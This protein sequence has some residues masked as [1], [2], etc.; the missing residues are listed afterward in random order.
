MEELAEIYEKKTGQKVLIDYAGSG[1][2]LV[3]IEQTGKGDLYVAH[4]PFLAAVLKKGLGIQGWTVASVEPVIAVPKGNPKNINGLTDL[5]KPGMKVILTHQD[6]STMGHLVPRMAEKSSLWKELEANVVSRTRGGGAAANAVMMGTADVTI[7]WNAVVHARKDKLDAIVI[8]PPFKL[9]KDIDAVSSATFG[10]IDMSHIRVT[11]ATL[12]CSKFPEKATQFAKFAASTQNAGIWEKHGFSK[13]KKQTDAKQKLIGGSIFVHCAAG[14]RKPV[15]KMAQEFH[16]NRG[17]KVELSYD[18]TNRLLGQ[19]KLTHQGDIYIAG[20]AD[21]IEMAAEQGLVKSKEILCYFLPVIMV[22]KNNPFKIEGLSDLL[23]DDIKIGQADEKAAAI[24]RLMP[25]LLNLNG[26]DHTKWQKNVVLSTPTVN[27]LGV[28]VKLGTL[29][30]AVVWRS[31][32]LNYAD[33]S[34]IIK[35]DPEKNIIPEVGGAVLNSSENPE[36]AAA[37]LNFVASN[38]GQEI[39]KECGYIVKL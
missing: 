19:I 7:V 9:N 36:A 16:E 23:K 3:K 29:D 13:P 28:G 2:C 39:L 35:L 34:E 38:R 32:A 14:M 6:Y 27:E 21:Y 15:S 22:Q 8:G 24:G 10:W 1:E 33:I 11:I 18:G 4:D 31:I 17:V 25:R 5:A 20:D 12:T 37:F 30:A 26:I